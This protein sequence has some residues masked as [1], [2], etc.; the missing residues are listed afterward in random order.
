MDLAKTLKKAR[1]AKNL[2]QEDVAKSLMVSRKT[3]SSWEN[4]RHL[5]SIE[6]ISE[7][8]ELY[9]ISFDEII[10]E[11]NHK[12]Q[13]KFV[14]FNKVKIFYGFNL[15]LLILQ[16]LNTLAPFNLHLVGITPLLIINLCC[17]ILVYHNWEVKLENKRDLIKVGIAGSI[18]LLI[19]AIVAASRIL[20]QYEVQFTLITF[21]SLIIY[22]GSLTASFLVA[23]YFC[24]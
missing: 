22:L 20:F 24:D 2:T 9:G 19:L 23:L 3:V 14:K 7:L 10:N 4:D 17:Y 12:P 13:H 1:I 11:K 16:L 15:L 5:P 8:S 21:I 18:F 6:T